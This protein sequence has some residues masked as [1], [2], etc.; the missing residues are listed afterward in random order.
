MIKMSL[1]NSIK[2]L[3]L[4]L[5]ITSQSPFL[6]FL[7]DTGSTH[8]ILFS[9]VLEALKDRFEPISSTIELSGIEGTNMTS[10]QVKGKIEFEGIESEVRFV[11]LAENKSISKIQN[12][13]G[14]QVHGIL[15]INFLLQN[16]WILDF[17]NLT[18][19]T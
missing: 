10:K 3:G 6:C 19:N 8:N 15:G 18:I 17:K 16:K 13:T 9:F 4:P 7:I 5:V 2:R 11:V 12:E 14:V 1:C